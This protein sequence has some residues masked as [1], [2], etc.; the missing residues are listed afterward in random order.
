MG[1]LRLPHRQYIVCGSAAQIAAQIAGERS[2]SSSGPQRKRDKLLCLQKN[3]QNHFVLATERRHKAIRV[4]P[5]KTKRSTCLPYLEPVGSRP[6]VQSH[7]AF[8]R[9]TTRSTHGKFN[10]AS[11]PRCAPSLKRSCFHSYQAISLQTRALLRPDMDWSWWFSNHSCP[12]GEHPLFNPYPE[13]TMTD[14]M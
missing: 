2:P 9:R 7:T 10:V 14:W 6:S 1:E 11:A 5:S 13:T 12:D 8:C 4:L 3:P